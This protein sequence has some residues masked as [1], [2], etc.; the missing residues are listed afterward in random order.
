MKET[1][2][3]KRK[4]MAFVCQVPA[5][6]AT[7]ELKL[8][9]AWHKLHYRYVIVLC[10]PEKKPIFLHPY[11]KRFETFIDEHIDWKFNDTH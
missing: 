6:Y 2:I 8:V 4:G 5:E 9:T 1:P 7:P 3:V 10:H 11:K